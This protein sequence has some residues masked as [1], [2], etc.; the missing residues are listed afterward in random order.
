MGDLLRQSI[1]AGGTMTTPGGRYF[2]LI[3]S[4]APVDIVFDFGGATKRIVGIDAGYAFGPLTEG[5]SFVRARISSAAAQSVAAFV[6]EDLEDFDRVLGLVQVYKPQSIATISD[7][8]VG[9]AS[10]TT[11]VAANAA[12][13]AVHLVNIGANP[14]RIG[15]ANTSNTRGARLDVGQSFT[16]ESVAQISGFSQLGTTIAITEETD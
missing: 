3:Q 1:G 13:R 15:D 7:V 12:R 16:I 6:G 11:L 10:L 8:V 4:A 2:K 14:I 9:A 5:E